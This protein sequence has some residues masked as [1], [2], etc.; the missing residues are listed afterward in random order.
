MKGVILAGGTGSRLHPL[1]RIT[2]KHLLPIYNRP[3]IEYTIEALVG[4]GVDPADVRIAIHELALVIAGQR[5]RPQT[6]SRPS[7]HL[8]EIE[9]GPF[10]RRVALPEPVDPKKASAT[11][12]RGLLT[13]V[14]PVTTVPPRRARISIQVRTI[15]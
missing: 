3:M 2:N 5:R 7:Y 11:Y 15:A 9:Y 4:A 14:L 1:T 8:M 13:I 12:E 10:E 6:E